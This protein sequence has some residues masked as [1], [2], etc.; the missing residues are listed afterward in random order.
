MNARSALGKRGET[1]AQQYLI[2]KGYSL[3]EKNWRFHHKEVDII[4]ADGADLV[5][6]EVKTRSSDWFG[7]PEE[8]V[9]FRKRKYLMKAAEAYIIM[10]NMETNIR[11]DVVSI[12]LR[13]GY[14]SVD[15][16][17]DAF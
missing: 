11:F 12:I 10:K 1:I 7:A 15:H 16:I 6:V 2:K 8:A 5:F 3:L 4:A 9:D 14:Q 17:K 13:S